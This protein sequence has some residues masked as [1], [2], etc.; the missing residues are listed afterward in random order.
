MA[1]KFDILVFGDQ[2]VSYDSSL[3]KLLSKKGNAI[4]SALFEEAHYT[5]R[6]EIAQLPPAEQAKFPPFSTLVELLTQHGASKSTNCALDSAFVC[7]H[8]LALFVNHFSEASITYPNPTTTYTVGICIGLLAATAV[9]CSHDVLDLVSIASQT[10]ATAF[11]LGLLVQEKSESIE[12]NNAS[13]GSCSFIVG[14]INEDTATELVKE[15]CCCEGV[16]STST[17]Y[18]SAVGNGSITMSGPPTSLRRFFAKSPTVKTTSVPVNGLFHAPHLYCTADVERISRPR[19]RSFKNRPQLIPVFSNES[20]AQ[21]YAKSFEKLL[22]SSLSEILEKQLRWDAIMEGLLATTCAHESSTWVIY[23]FASGSVQGLATA[24]G[25]APSTTAEIQKTFAQSQ[26]SE[27]TNAESR[28]AKGKIAIIGFSGRFP[29]ADNNEA[30]WQLLMNGLDVH[31]EIPKDRFD[32]WL[33][34]DPTGKKKNTSAV[35]KGC[36][37][38]QPGLF[39]ARFFGLSPREAEQADPAQRLALMT[40]YEAIEMAGLV[41]DATPSTQRNRVGVFYGTTSDDW[42]EVNSGQNVD[43]YFIPGGNRAFVPGRINY[44]F[45]FSGPSYSVDTACSSSLAAIHIACNS[46]WRRDCDTVIAGGTNVMTNPDNF[47]GLD[48]GHFL[49]RTGNCNTFDDAADGYCRAECVGS[50][51]LKRLEDAQADGDPVFGTIL[52]TATNH[53]AESV[54]ITRPHSGAQEAIFKRILNSAGVDQSEISYVE[55]HGT[56]TQQGDAVEMKSVLSVFSP[57]LTSRAQSLHLGSAKSNIGHSESSS[58]VASLIKVLL[59][60]ENSTIPPHVGIKTKINRNFPTDLAQ[61]NVHIAMKPTS[62]PKPL[63]NQPRKAFVNNFSAAGG[64]SSVLI[65]DAPVQNPGRNDPRPLHLVAVS[66]KSSTSLKNSIRSLR[67]FLDENPEIS[68]GSLSYTTSARRIHHNFRIMISGSQISDI[69]EALKVKEESEIFLSIPSTPADIGFCFTGQGSQ[70]LGMGRHLLEIPQICATIN[71]FEETIHAYGFSSILPILDGSCSV[72]L[73]TLPPSTLQL[74]ITC[75]QMA[76]HKFWKSLGI[77]PKLVIGHSLGEYAA[78]NAAGIISD[79]ETIFLVGVRARLL[80]KYCT[81]GTHAMLAIKASVRTLASYLES[82]TSLEIACINGPEDTVISGSN[83]DIAAL[84]S[85]LANSSI[86]AT[87]LSVQ[88]AFHS[89]QV[90]PML[91]AFEHATRSI[92]FKEPSIPIISPLFGNVITAASDLG[93][94]SKYLSRH[95]RETV[96]F[97]AALTSAS[98]SKAIS[99]KMLWLEVGPHPVCSAMLGSTL[100]SQFRAYPSLRRTED[101]WKTLTSTL[102]SLYE[103]G[104]PINWPEYH[105]GFKDDLRVLKLPS[106]KWDLKNYWITYR[107]DW[108]LTKGDA[109]PQVAPSPPSDEKS[110]TQNF[111][112]SVQRITDEIFSTTEASVTA[113][114]D[115]NNPEFQKLLEG[116]RVNGQPLCTS[117]AYADMALT[118]FHHLLERSPL[119]DKKE[120]GIEVRSMVAGKSLVFAGQSSQRIRMSASANWS[121]RTSS[122]SLCSISEDG[123]PTINHANCVGAFSPRK[124]WVSEW[125]RQEFLIKSRIEHLQQ[126][127][128]D[129]DSAHLIKTRMFYKLFSA[130]VDYSDG[131]KG[132][133]ELILRSADHEATGKVKFT[134]ASSQS[135]TWFCNPYWI[136][137]IGQITG[138]TM[139]ANDFVDLKKTVYI[140]HGWKNLRIAAPF[141]AEKT[142]QTYVKMQ[143][144]GANEY[145]GNIYVL[146]QGEIVAVYEGVTFAA[147][148]RKVL[149]LVIPNPLTK[150]QVM[151]QSSIAPNNK[152][153]VSMSAPM[154]APIPTLTPTNSHLGVDR[155]KAIIAEEVGVPISDIDDNEELTNLGVDSLLS[156]TMSEKIREEVGIAIDSRVFLEGTTVKGLCELIAPKP[157]TSEPSTTPI[158]TDS[159]TSMS[160]ST[161]TTLSESGH[162]TPMTIYPPALGLVESRGSTHTLLD[163]VTRI[164][165]EEIG[166]QP[167][168]L[169]DDAEL[170]SLGL[171]SLMSLTVLSELKEKLGLELEPDFLL[172][173]DTMGAIRQSLMQHAT[174]FSNATT[175]DSHIPQLSVSPLM[176]PASSVL[177]QGNLKTASKTLWLFPDGSGLATSY[178]SLPEIGTNTVVLGLNSPFIKKAEEMKCT[179]RELSTVYLA[180]IRRRQPHGPY[181]L[182]GW[183]AGGICAYDCAQNLT[184]AGETVSRLILLDSPNPIDLEMLPPSLYE[185]FDSMNLFGEAGRKP[186]AW[187]LPHFLAFINVLDTYKPVPFQHKA[188]PETW[189][190]WAKDGVAKRGGVEVKGDETREMRWLLN[191]RTELGGNGWDQ[192]VGEERLRIQVLEGSDHFSMLKEGREKVGSFIRSAME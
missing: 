1:G 135:G 162:T 35:T 163:T 14:G 68:L 114:S 171:D 92:I 83:A 127:L 186:P 86:K 8:Q 150:K 157:P 155:V 109:P 20:G 65:E 141:S 119:P 167:S 36:F 59:M 16:P 131:F 33:Y 73:P 90:E 5:L 62:W 148:E 22:I 179:L 72:E 99:E 143:K 37:I 46:L 128:H 159:S 79:S 19:S 51:V 4:L 151:L 181:F 28:S 160:T 176:P 175:T 45:K 105:H 41:P 77:R 132:Y 23:P 192:L 108:C 71:R 138:F 134:P 152:S 12:S 178:L 52:G 116:H 161:S 60:M 38:R 17:P 13:T 98:A 153:Q 154:P 26:Q 130:L 11:R 10:I 183:S 74:A 149:D 168:D 146:D 101:S 50:V 113:V 61:R 103:K 81:V 123:K 80:E 6:E 112:T 27:E 66:A 82:Q 125:K 76:L 158:L 63:A 185:L 174:E 34:Y 137:S 144:Q 117:S 173:Y 18:I 31:R 110:S 39:D 124:D 184:A 54:S 91:D 58:G 69:I 84:A 94:P 126:T 145:S 140:N 67:S 187:L 56:G 43:T 129:S 170:S 53:S 100:G 190:L 107:H 57:D 29:D 142:Y 47:A 30:F 15:Y 95:C 3:L 189:I 9:S 111:T 93:E 40:A 133:R 70:Y 2:A 48:K 180:E 188:G 42:R 166:V 89:A 165:S 121:T 97:N 25:R 156:L 172:T 102:T 49:S 96:N 136:D 64:N 87:Q 85:S 75:L 78:M 182:G 164:L 118:L 115:L 106:Y 122:F 44:H 177:L 32:P 104:I 55:M 169:K 120:L 147:I 21:T 191:E 24:I 88:F 7:L 139:N